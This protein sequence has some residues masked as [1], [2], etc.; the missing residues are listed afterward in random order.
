M[1]LDTANVFEG[2]FEGDLKHGNGRFK[3]YTEY[4]VSKQKSMIKNN[5]EEIHRTWDPL[6]FEGVFSYGDEQVEKSKYS[7]RY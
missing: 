2:N 3:V 5:I 1:H 4:E 7:K 6:L